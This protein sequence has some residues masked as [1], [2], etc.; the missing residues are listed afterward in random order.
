MRLKARLLVEGFD[1][2]HLWGWKDPRNSL[3]LQ[4]WQDLAGFETCW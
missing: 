3:T 2:V 4:F 1:S